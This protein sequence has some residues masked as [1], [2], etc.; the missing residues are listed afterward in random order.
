MKEVVKATSPTFPK[1]L[2]SSKQT[3][4]L[5]RLPLGYLS[6]HFSIPLVIPAMRHCLQAREDRRGGN[7]R[8]KLLS[9][10][11]GYIVISLCSLY[12]GQVWEILRKK[13][14]YNR[15]PQPKSV[16]SLNKG[17]GKYENSRRRGIY[18]KNSNTSTRNTRE[19]IR[20][21]GGRERMY[22]TCIRPDRASPIH[23]TFPAQTNCYA[24][25]E[26]TSP[27]KIE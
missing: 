17:I 16:L 9:L 22:F 15:T 20:K 8:G 3:P 25:R 4:Q 10:L 11:D 21:I 19:V 14:Y 12:K 6:P 1:R 5:Y 26:I 27:Q 13:F 7:K 18:G 23:P 2:Q 24:C